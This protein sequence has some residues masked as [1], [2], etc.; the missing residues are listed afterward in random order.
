MRKTKVLV[1]TLKTQV[2]LAPIALGIFAVFMFMLY[3]WQ[4]SMATT[5][6]YAM[7]DLEGDI[8]GL[9]R[10]IASQQVKISNLSSVDS[11]TSRMHL[12]GLTKSQD[13][14]HVFTS[15]NNV[16]VR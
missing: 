4:L 13:V 14:T 5:A 7:R 15:S 3:M 9:K 11:V 12:L 2:G 6:G 8:T 1:K 16:A 10:E